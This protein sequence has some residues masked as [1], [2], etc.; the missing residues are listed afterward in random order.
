MKSRVIAVLA[1][2][3]AVIGLGVAM[4][5]PLRPSDSADHSASLAV[6]ATESDSDRLSLVALLERLEALLS[7]LR[8]A[9]DERM[10]D[11]QPGTLKPLDDGSE[12][13]EDV[14]VASEEQDD[15]PCEVQH[16]SGPGW[17]RTQVR[18]HHEEVTNNGNSISVSSSSSSSTTTTSSSSD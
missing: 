15:G 6:R 9:L 14:D 12:A 8:Q 11:E 3:L 5:G 4:A 2:V 13:D 7:E 10:D 16:E 17:N 1:I 18:C